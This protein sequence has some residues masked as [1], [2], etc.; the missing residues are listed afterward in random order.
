[1]A[2]EGCHSQTQLWSYSLYGL[3]LLFVVLVALKGRVVRRGVGVP[4]HQRLDGLIRR[5][6]RAD[7]RRLGCL[8]KVAPARRVEAGHEGAESGRIPP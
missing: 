2:L 5:L 3:A 8:G 1:M 7:Q 4:Q 6:H